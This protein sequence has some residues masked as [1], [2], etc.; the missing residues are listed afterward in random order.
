M[1]TK[2]VGCVALMETTSKDGFGAAVCCD[3][4]G[5]AAN[6]TAAIIKITAV[7][8]SIGISPVLL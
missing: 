1:A 6:A 8:L 3:L 4:R 7:T 5:I 2:F